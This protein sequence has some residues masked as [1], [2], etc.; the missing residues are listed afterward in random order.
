MV[1]M[2]DALTAIKDYVWIGAL[3]GLLLGILNAYFGGGWGSKGIS[4]TFALTRARK[5]DHLRKRRERLIQLHESDREYY[6]WLLTGVLSVLALF[7]GQLVLEAS[8]MG[9]YHFGSP[10]AQWRAGFVLASGRYLIGLVAYF[11]AVNRV[12]DYHALRRFDR[13]IATL[14]RRIATLA[15]GAS[16]LMSEGTTAP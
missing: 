5:L 7:A 2:A 8:L 10:E 4:W 14:D 15:A 3:I 11:G 16:G 9:P 13:T 12:Q 6:G 1:T